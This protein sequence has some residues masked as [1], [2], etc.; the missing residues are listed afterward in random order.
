MNKFI[1]LIFLSIQTSYASTCDTLVIKNYYEKSNTLLSKDLDKA[2][3]LAKKAYS[4]AKECP[5]T[6][7]YYESVISLSAAYY[8]Q[9]QADSIIAIVLPAL[10]SMNSS[11]PIF[12]RAGIHHKLSTGYTML[13]QF[14][15]GLKYSFSALK[16]YEQIDQ[17]SNVV[18]MLVNIANVYQQQNNFKQADKYLRQAEKI[19]KQID[20]KTVLG[21]VYNTLGILYAEHNLLDSAEKFFLLSTDIREKLNDNTS[22]AW[23]YNNLGGLYVLLGKPEK[24]IVFLEKALAKFEQNNN[25]DGQTSA[26]NNIGEVYTQ[27]KNYKKALEYFQYSRKLYAKTDNPDNLE[28]LFNNLSNYYS[29]LGDYK[30]AL[31][32]SDSLIYLKDSL[33]GKRLDISIAEMQTKFDV[34]KKDLE[35]ASTKSK[36]EV[37]EKQNYIKNIIIVSG[38][39]VSI[40]IGVF[41]LSI[42]KRRK[43]ENK[44]KLEAEIAKQNDIRSKAVIDAE[45]KERVRIAKDLHDGVGQ[46]LSAAKLNLSSLQDKLEKTDT[47]S[48]QLL[49][50]ASNLVDDSVK[51]VRTVSHSMMPNALLKLGLA[52]AVKDFINKLSS[53]N[54]LKVDLEIVGLETRLEPNTETT[55]FRVL[56]EIV[57]NIIKHAKANYISV[58]LIQHEK[59]LTLMVEDNGVGFDTTKINSFEGIGLKNIQSRVAFLN[60]SINFDSTENKGT[61]IVIEVPLK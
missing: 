41:L 38:L 15:E 54:K 55:L 52:S 20:R 25:Y 8:Q 7:Y 21:N 34:E 1:I 60:G 22:I 44:L 2:L 37:K 10:N 5:N 43:I 31:T 49:N 48:L 50:N 16:L 36:L 56:Q 29:K 61:T 4:L 23:N 40:L 6:I 32:Y 13:M 33:Y 24:A 18:N 45:E 11:T 42:F 35:I 58:Q 27:L 46:L 17:K 59:E 47:E 3:S 57:N 30:T 39:L 51:E 14:E 26:S 9:D 19:G 28:N 12:Y 53:G